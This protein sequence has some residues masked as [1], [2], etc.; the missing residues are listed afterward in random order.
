MD[1]FKQSVMVALL[2]MAAPW[3]KTAL[4][5]L[6][7][8][9]VGEKSDLRPTDY[10][11]LSKAAA[12]IAMSHRPIM[13]TVSGFDKFGEEPNKVDVVKFRP[14][15]ELMAMHNRVA[16]WDMGSTFP[17]NPHLTIGPIG[18]LD[19]SV[20]GVILFDRVLVSWGEEQLTFWLKP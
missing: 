9:Y 10:N 8:A 1:E 7:L 4:P 20:P 17:F 15:P 16:S 13:L 19:G 11:H 12:D 6:T 14:T 2:P 5:H 3:A 18:S